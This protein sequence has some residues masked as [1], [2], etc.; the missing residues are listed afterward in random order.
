[1]RHK[2]KKIKTMM[3]LTG[4]EFRANQS[5][6]FNAAKDGEDVVIKSRAGSFRIVPITDDD[7]VVG[8]DELA[9]SLYRSLLEVKN[10]REGKGKLLSWE[11]MMHELEKG[12][13]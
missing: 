11:E 7:I 13:K 6:Y 10:A 9:E 4:R 3:V 12:N 2:S 8:K 1:M 5:K